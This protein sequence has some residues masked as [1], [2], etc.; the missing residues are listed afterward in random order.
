MD[1]WGAHLWFV[2]C[3]CLCPQPPAGLPCTSLYVPGLCLCV[4]MSADGTRRCG[5]GWRTKREKGDGGEQGHGVY[6]YQALPTNLG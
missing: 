6:V 2:G 5:K 4:Q 3:A 1:K